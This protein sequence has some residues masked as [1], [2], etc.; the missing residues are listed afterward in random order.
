MKQTSLQVD[1][2]SAIVFSKVC[3]RLYLATIGVLW[4][5]VLY[6]QIGLRQ[7]V[8]EF[9]DIAILL[10]AN[11]ILAIAAIL[12]LGGVTIPRFRVSLVAGF[13][14]ISVTAGT[15]FWLA[16]DPTAALGKLLTVASIS[17]ILILLYLLVALLGIKA[18]NKRLEE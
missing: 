4:L 12:Y 6:R 8:T 9:M 2:R 13:Y 3:T 15:V 11:V 10:T 16:K 7:P 1:E 5:D 18:T 17:G 14:A